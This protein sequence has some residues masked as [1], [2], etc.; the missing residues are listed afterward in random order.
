MKPKT[1]SPRRGDASLL[2]LLFM[3]KPGRALIGRARIDRSVTR[4]WR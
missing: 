2:D 4:R 3:L 1:A